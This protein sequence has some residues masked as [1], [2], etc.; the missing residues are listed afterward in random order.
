[1]CGQRRR[2]DRDGLDQWAVGKKESDGKEG[3]WRDAEDGVLSGST[4]VQ[5]AVDSVGALHLSSRRRGDD[6]LVLD[7]LRFL[8]RRGRH[9][10][11]RDHRQVA[12]DAAGAYEAYWRV[13]ANAE[14]HELAGLTTGVADLFSAA[15]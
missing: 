2:R 11:L 6:G 3:T 4:V 13:W 9:G 8:L 1:M 5:G 10:E 15:C 12:G 7:R 14:G